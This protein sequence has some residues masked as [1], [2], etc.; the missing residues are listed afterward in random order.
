[1]FARH[2]SGLRTKIM[3]KCDTQIYL[4]VV[5]AKAKTNPT[6]YF[7]SQKVASSIC[8]LHKRSSQLLFWLSES[9]HRKKGG[10]K[11]F[12]TQGSK[13]SWQIQTLMSFEKESEKTRKMSE[14]LRH[15]QKVMK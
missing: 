3:P 12:K 2:K 4:S 5:S 8:L 9:D 6:P 7:S 1:M 13:Q 14:K 15:S 11:I 10:K